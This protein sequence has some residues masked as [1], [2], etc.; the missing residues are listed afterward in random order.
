MISFPFLSCHQRGTLI[1][2]T[3]IKV[4]Y[5]MLA[6][7]TTLPKERYNYSLASMDCPCDLSQ[8][9][10]QP[11][12]GQCMHFIGWC[13]CKSQNATK[14]NCSKQRFI[15][16]VE[17]SAY[18]VRISRKVKWGQMKGNRQNLLGDFINNCRWNDV[19][20]S[21]CLKIELKFRKVVNHI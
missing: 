18:A 14:S 15:P 4:F 3:N 20:T 8:D 6:G 13:T 7:T 16:G 17:A 21:I 9:T 5:I 11:I 2:I 1:A 12:S 10:F 19:F